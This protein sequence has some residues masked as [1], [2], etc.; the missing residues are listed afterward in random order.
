MSARTPL[1]KYLLTALLA[2]SLSSCAA[3]GASYR[4]AKISG[5]SGAEIWRQIQE[6]AKTRGFRADPEVTDIGRKIYQS[7]WVGQ[8]VSFRRGD[9][10]RVWARI[11]RDDDEVADWLVRFYVEVEWVGDSAKNMQPEE[12][13]WEFSH[14]DGVKESEF[15]RV[16][17]LAFPH[18]R[19]DSDKPGGVEART[20][21]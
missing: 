1:T 17:T 2:W 11:L 5:Y 19:R 15:R 10:K 7:R 13:D 9:R 6:F 3:Y 16:L 20:G 18:K 4:E 14:Q 21:R 8:S 12:D